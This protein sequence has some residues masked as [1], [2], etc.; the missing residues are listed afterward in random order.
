VF[1]LPGQI[2]HGAAG[3]E[4]RERVE[5][6]HLV[7]EGHPV[8]QVT[9]A[10]PGPVL[11]PAVQGV[12]GERDEP[13]HRHGGP[14]DVEQLHRGALGRQQLA[15]GVGKAGDDIHGGP[16]R[17]FRRGRADLPDQ[18]GQP[19]F[20]ASSRHPGAPVP[21][22]EGGEAVDHRDQISGH[23][24]HVRLVER[25]TRPVRHT[26]RDHS[27]GLVEEHD[28][29]PAGPRGDRLSPRRRNPVDQPGDLVGVLSRDK[30]IAFRCRCGSPSSV[31]IAA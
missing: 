9:V 8:R 28:L 23:P 3:D 2:L 18:A 31:W 27:A 16:L 17:C 25:D 22:P 30:N 29:L 14:D 26:P 24:P 20:P 11:G 12:P 13:G 10:Q 6:P 15:V 4:R 5:T 19:A 7:G 21:W 1:T